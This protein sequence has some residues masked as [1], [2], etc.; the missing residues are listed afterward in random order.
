MKIFLILNGSIGRRFLSS[1]NYDYIKISGIC[2]NKKSNDFNYFQKF[3]KKNCFE[4]FDHKSIKS[5]KFKIWLSNNFIDLIL[6]IFSFEII[7]S[8]I[9]HIPKIGFFN[10]HPGKLPE[11][12]GNFPGCRLKKP[13]FGIFNIS[14]GI[15]S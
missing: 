14:D 13:I 8:D 7:P 15:I 5:K 3:S 9:I 1:L 6:N 2:V 4:L 12:S 10:L 11:Y